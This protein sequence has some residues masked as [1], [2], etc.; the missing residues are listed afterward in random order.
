MI[1]PSRAIVLGAVQ[2]P[3]ELLPIS[4]SGPLTLI[5]WLLGWD[6]EDGDPELQNSFGVSL[7]AGAA[8]ALLIGQR[9][10]I[11]EELRTFDARK[12]AVLA[13]S[14]LPAALCGLAFE[15]RIGKFQAVPQNLARLAGEVAAALAATGSAADTLAQTDT[16]DDV[17]LLEAASAKI[18][19]A[20][21]A[22]EGSAIAHQVFGAIGFTNEHVL[23]RFT[24]RMLGVWFDW[25]LPRWPSVA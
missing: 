15:R 22:S 8:A 18:R 11:A 25:N 5:P 2:G 23:H 13:L 10:V 14:F 17:V 6:A 4:S 7:H 12:A 20:E 24:L 1:R 21:A 3:T 19:S 16:F 9:R